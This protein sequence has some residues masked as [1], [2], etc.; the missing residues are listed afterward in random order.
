MMKL[1]MPERTAR[2]P[3]TE[4]SG[5]PWIIIFRI[6]SIY[7]LAGTMQEIPRKKPGRFSIGKIIPDSIRIGNIITI[8]DNSNAASWVV[9][10]VEI[11]SPR[12]RD[13]AT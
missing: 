9:T 10:S 4:V 8:A 1:A 6:A 7:H 12:H 13:N 5:S 11:S 3:A 2:S